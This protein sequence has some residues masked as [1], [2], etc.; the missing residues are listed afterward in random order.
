MNIQPLKGAAIIPLLAAMAT[1]EVSFSS[2]AS[3]VPAFENVTTTAGIVSTTEET[4]S[5]SWVDFNSDG[6]PDLWITPHGY[7]SSDQPKGAK[8]P[9]LYLNQGSGTFTNIISSIWPV[10]I[11]EDTH[12]SAW[13][14]FDND[15]DP[16]LFVLTGADA[17]S[18][19]G[20]KLFFVNNEG[21][22]QERAIA[23]GL[24]YSLGRGR[25]PLWFDWN[26]DGLLDI[27]LTTEKRRDGLAPTA[28]FGQTPTGFKNVSTSVGLQADETSHFAQ[29]ADLSDD[30]KLDLI[31][32]GGSKYPQ[33]LYDT[34]TVP[35]KNLTTTV[36][37][38]SNVS[39]AVIADFNGDLHPDLFLPRNKSA[40]V[41]SIFQADANVAL[42]NLVANKTEVGVSFK[43]PGNVGFDFRTS[44]VTEV[45][46]ELSRS[47]I[48]IGSQGRNPTNLGFSLSPN[49]PSVRGIKPHTPGSASALY[50]GY[51]STSQTWK[52]L[53]SSSRYKDINLVIEAANP[54][55]DLTKIGFGQLNL[56][57]HDLQ[58]VLLMYDTTTNKYVDQTQVSG[59]GN[60]ILGQSAVAGDFDNDMDVDLYV[61]RGYKTFNLPSILYENKG[62][63]TFIEV[64]NAGGAAG[65]NLGFHFSALSTKFMTGSRI[66]VADYDVDGFL[67][68]FVSN[69]VFRATQKT[70]LGSPHQLFR[71]LGNNNHWIEIDLKGVV[72]NR[73]GI[74]TRVLVTAGGVTQLR[75]QGGGMH[76]FSQN[77]QRIHFGLGSNPQ[78][79]KIEIHW[80]SGVVQ[81]IT[82]VSADQV[83][84]V[85]EWNS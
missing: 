31:I 3:A 65:S 82:N 53:F 30:G 40:H 44:P 37:A 42:A 5:V 41:S 80:P 1:L 84:Q 51:D 62:N 60:P 68:L 57:Q 32:Q 55:S 46:I 27:L 54:L 28:L 50:I 74:G 39:D 77:Q 20:R 36:P 76:L 22:L 78:V 17:G 63:G 85:V 13:A 67:D 9:S 34:T 15:D 8:F 75:E 33:K 10:G 18:G 72:S 56:S 25:S 70:Y 73:D 23:L 6:K 2:R 19:S 58:D 43:T 47:Q 81:N 14:D 66:A 29:V 61:S 83:L 12:G 24:D 52:A 45:P 11:T 7:R 69:T 59:L 4:F 26:K 79:D 48:F 38:Y 49:D 71:N 35:F 64:S 21:Q 16:D